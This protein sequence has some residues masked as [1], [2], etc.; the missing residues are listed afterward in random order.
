MN[1]SLQLLHLLLHDIRH[2]HGLAIRR[3]INVDI[4]RVQTIYPII[5]V[6]ILVLHLHGS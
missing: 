1:A 3:N 2:P 5:A 6:G 4:Y